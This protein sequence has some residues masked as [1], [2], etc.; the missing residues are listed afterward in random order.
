MAV[1][2][3]FEVLID[4]SWISRVTVFNSRG[5]SHFTTDTVEEAE[6]VKAILEGIPEMVR[7]LL[8]RRSSSVDSLPD[9][10]S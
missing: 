4:K 10:T 8:S 1:E 9:L 2:S 3:H 7:V 5:R 6:T